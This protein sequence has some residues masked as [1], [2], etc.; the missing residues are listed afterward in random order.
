MEWLKRLHRHRYG[1]SL[2]AYVVAAI[3]TGSACVLFARAFEWVLVRRLDFASVGAWAWLAAPIGF[4]IAVE[5][6]RR[7][8]PF[9]AGTGI[10]QAIFASEH[11]AAENEKRIYPLLSPWTITV[12]VFTLLLGVWV[13]ASTGREGP[14][15]HCRIVG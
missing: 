4:L 13:G 1:F 8:A 3:A 2:F 14:T 12:K 15:V 7:Y 10:P 5:I 11:F 6:I 9:A